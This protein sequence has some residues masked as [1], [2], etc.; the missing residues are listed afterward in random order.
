MYPYLTSNWIYNRDGFGLIVKN[1][2]NGLAKINSYKV[3]N[4]SIYFKEWLDVIKVYMPEA[5]NINFSL[6]T[7]S[8]N[9]REQ[10]VSPGETKKLIFIRWTDETRELERRVT[11]LK[12]SISYSSLLEEHWAIK[13]GIP[14]KTRKKPILVEQEFGF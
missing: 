9:I 1:S 2:G 6:I 3:F 4:D 7:T 14:E 8:G 10:M 12:V 5:V 13:N 11:D